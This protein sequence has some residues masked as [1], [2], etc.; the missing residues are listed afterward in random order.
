MEHKA[1]HLAG[2]SLKASIKF[3]VCLVVLLLL[4]IGAVY[5]QD[6]VAT[7]RFPQTFA[8]GSSDHLGVR[9]VLIPDV[10]RLTLG[11][12]SR[13]TIMS[14]SNSFVLVRLE[15]GSFVVDFL[16]NVDIMVRGGASDEAL[17][18]TA[19]DEPMGTFFLLD[20]EAGVLYR[21]SRSGAHPFTRT[22]LNLNNRRQSTTNFG[23]IGL[24]IDQNIWHYASFILR[25][26]AAYI[27]VTSGFGLNVRLTVKIA[28]VLSYLNETTS[29]TEEIQALLEKLDVAMRIDFAGLH[30]TLEANWL[31]ERL[32]PISGST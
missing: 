20:S 28:I 4:S 25:D 26:V 22:E 32:R 16:C 18:T 19:N 31:L 21:Y 17:R 3:I 6:E 13:L 1:K 30:R 23:A 15:E 8:S 9:Q 2:A 10:M 29:F 11:P 7:G 24:Q 12:S 27:D 5:A 14:V